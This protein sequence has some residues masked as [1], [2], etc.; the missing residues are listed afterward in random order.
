MEVLWKFFRMCKFRSTSS[1]AHE[2]LVWLGGSFGSVLSSQVL[3][4]TFYERILVFDSLLLYE[5][6]EPLG[7]HLLVEWLGRSS[8]RLTR[9]DAHRLFLLVF[10][11]LLLFVLLVPTPVLHIGGLLMAYGT[12]C[13][14]CFECGTFRDLKLI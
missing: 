13:G 5:F 11:R 10:L 2:I 3:W 9:R 8:L 12:L 6:L 14:L 4:Q 7:H 1:E